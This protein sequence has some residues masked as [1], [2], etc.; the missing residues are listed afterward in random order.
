VTTP[1]PPAGTSADEPAPAE[2]PALTI[3]ALGRKCPIPIIMLAERIGEV[4]VGQLV[5][6]LSDDPAAKTDLPA[7]C[8]LKS[9]QFEGITELPRGWSFLVRRSY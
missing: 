3:D 2:S 6:V 1:R 5:A 7:W 4:R 9:Q 8:M